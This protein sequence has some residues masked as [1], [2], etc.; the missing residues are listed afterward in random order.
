MKRRDSQRRA[1][2]ADV[3]VETFL[4]FRAGLGEGLEHFPDPQENLMGDHVILILGYITGLIDGE[5][6]SFLPVLVQQA[7]CR[8]EYVLIRKHDISF[9]GWGKRSLKAV[10]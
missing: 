3:L 9:A 4:A 1:N 2:R 5:N 6:C 8:L 10:G 7:F